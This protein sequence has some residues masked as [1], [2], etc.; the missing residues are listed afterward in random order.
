MGILHRAVAAVQLA[1]AAVADG[2]NVRP[3]KPTTSVTRP[4]R[5]QPTGCSLTFHSTFFEKKVRVETGTGRS[6]EGLGYQEIGSKYA[7]VM[8]VS[9]QQTG[10]PEKGALN[11]SISAEALRIEFIDMVQAQPNEN[12]LVLNFVQRLAL[13][14]ADIE[15]PGTPTGR[16][17]GRFAFGW[18]HIRRL[19]DL[20]D[21]QL[22]QR[23]KPVDIEE[24]KS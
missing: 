11:L 20:L 5:E 24:A 7:G 17:A 12:V 3:S 6:E 1:Q 13:P 2:Q 18:E 8:I 4:V 10:L 16:L 21:R 14:L 15:D 23:Q 22:E 19:R 9:E